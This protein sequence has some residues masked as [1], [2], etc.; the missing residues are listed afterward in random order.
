MQFPPRLFLLL[1]VPLLLK[2]QNPVETGPG[3]AA[4]KM[5]VRHAFAGIAAEQKIYLQSDRRR[6]EY[7][8][9]T[10]LRNGPHIASITR[11]DLGQMFELNLDDK[12]YLTAPYPPKPLTREQAEERGFKTSVSSMP[13]EPTLRIETVTVDTL[14]RKEVFGHMARHVITT[15]KEIPLAGSP[16]Q[17]QESV[18][19][20][21]YIDVDTRISCDRRWLQTRNAGAYLR[22][23]SAAPE[24]VELVT[25]GDPETG[26]AIEWKI[27]SR[28]TYTLPD[29]TKKEATSTS[30][31]RITEF[32]EGPLNPAVFEIPPDFRHVDHI[33]RNPPQTMAELWNNTRQWLKVVTGWFYH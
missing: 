17:E 21:W 31:M 27:I 7:Q 8:N 4:I 26:L 13:S 22:V 32:V 16:R 6:M 18:T 12:E 20:G 23:R 10:N 3:A 15:R 29:G 19:D 25:N 5:T 2:F 24:K 30:E 14:E 11:C 33:A 28:G 9:G 1:C